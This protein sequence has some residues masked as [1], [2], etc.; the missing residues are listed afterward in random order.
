MCSGT[1]LFVLQGFPIL[2]KRLMLVR[3]PIEDAATGATAE[4]GVDSENSPFSSA[5]KVLLCQ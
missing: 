4:D 3:L 5:I 2:L 1:R